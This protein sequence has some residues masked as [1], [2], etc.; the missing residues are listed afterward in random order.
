MEI[1]TEDALLT[2][3]HQS[4]VVGIVAKQSLVTI[5][6]RKVLVKP[7]PVGRPIVGCPNYGAGLTP[8]VATLV[9]EKGY[10][11]YVKIDN[12][13]VCLDT[14]VGKTTG[15]PGPF[16]YAVRRSGQTLVKEN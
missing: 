15:T 6:G 12:D 14:V 9:V 16:D 3:A 10:S 1:L 2:C 7:D 4:G 8:C 13:A 11:A 5:N